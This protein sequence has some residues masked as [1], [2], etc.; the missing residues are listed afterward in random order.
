MKNSVNFQRNMNVVMSRVDRTGGARGVRTP[1]GFWDERPKFS[2]N[3]ASMHDSK[4]M[5]HPLISVAR[6][7]H[8]SEDWFSLA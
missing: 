4:A 1:P 2:S 7:G 6:V 5:L 8:V 3:F